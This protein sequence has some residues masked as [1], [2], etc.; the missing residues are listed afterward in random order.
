MDPWLPCRGSRIHFRRYRFHRAHA[1]P[2]PVPGSADFR[3]D[4]IHIGRADSLQR[5]CLP[6]RVLLIER[7][8]VPGR[9]SADERVYILAGVFISAFDRIRIPELIPVRLPDP[10]PDSFPVPFPVPF[11]IGLPD[12]HPHHLIHVLASIQAD[13]TARIGSVNISG[14]D[15]G[16]QLNGLGLRD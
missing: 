9:I 2:E 7:I 15:A 16:A 8:I 4:S 1:R 11:G 5:V 13:I 14:A 12:P 6:E 10:D 3:T